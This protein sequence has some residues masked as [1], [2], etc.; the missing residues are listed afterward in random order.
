LQLLF[1]HATILAISLADLAE[2]ADVEPMHIRTFG[3][4]VKRNP[5]RLALA[6]RKFVEEEVRAITEA[7]LVFEGE[8]DWSSSTFC[9]QKAGTTKL[10][11]VQDLR[12]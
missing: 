5:I 2:P 8:S 10:R 7:G 9:V 12:A 4:P 11:L 6:H 1:D 3:Q